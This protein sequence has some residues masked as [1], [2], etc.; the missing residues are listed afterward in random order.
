LSKLGVYARSVA[1]FDSSRSGQRCYVASGINPSNVVKP[2]FGNVKYT[3]GIQRQTDRAIKYRIASRS[4][5]DT[6]GSAT[7]KR[8]DAPG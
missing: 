1:K 5:R 7:R 8:A 4:V 3:I 2:K 6:A